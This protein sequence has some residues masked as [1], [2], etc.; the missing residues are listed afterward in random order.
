MEF[1]NGKDDIP[2]MKWKI[3]FM[4]EST[5]QILFSDWVFCLKGPALSWSWHKGHP[6]GPVP[7]KSETY[8]IRVVG[9]YEGGLNSSSSRPST[10]NNV[11]Q[12]FPSGWNSTFQPYV[13]WHNVFA[14]TWHTRHGL[15]SHIFWMLRGTKRH[16]PRAAHFPK[17][18]AINWNIPYWLV[19]STPLKN[20]S[21]LG[22]IIPNIWKNKKCSKPPTSLCRDKRIKN[23]IVSFTQW[24]SREHY[25]WL[26][27]PMFLDTPCHYHIDRNYCGCSLPLYPHFCCL[28]NFC[29][30][31]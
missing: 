19:V 23:C 10:N 29:W 13:T 27:A 16:P 12:Q 17:C 26:Y 31:L 5:N 2:Y 8:G 4:F 14:G 11:F 18:T 20:M 25:G 3:K 9:M 21:Q 6:C 24:Y 7:C 1:V 30:L 28:K 22:V 15:Q